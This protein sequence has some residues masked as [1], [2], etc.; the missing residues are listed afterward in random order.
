MALRKTRISALATLLAAT[1]A[2]GN[3]LLKNFD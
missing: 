3:L 1:T 2:S